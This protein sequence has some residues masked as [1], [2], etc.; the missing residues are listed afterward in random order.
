MPFGIGF[1]G[2]RTLN[3]QG[4]CRRR[5]SLSGP[6]YKNRPDY[7]F[8]GSSTEMHRISL[9]WRKTCPLISGCLGYLH[10]QNAAAATEIAYETWTWH[11]EK[12]TDQFRLRHVNLRS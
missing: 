5:K 6:T 2:I 12:S 9:V 7:N 1:F 10:R 4:T 11:I 3:G 8:S